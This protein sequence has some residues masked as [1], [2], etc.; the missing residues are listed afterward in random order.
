MLWSSSVRGSGEKARGGMRGGVGVCVYGG[1][2]EL[3]VCIRDD[4][5]VQLRA[6]ISL[7]L[8][9]AS[10]PVSPVLFFKSPQKKNKPNY[11]CCFFAHKR[12]KKGAELVSKMLIGGRWRGGGALEILILTHSLDFATR[13]QGV[14]DCSPEFL[15]LL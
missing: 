13:F 9:R 10:C 7:L 8:F 3:N 2:G 5:P 1:D 11:Y 12:K 6:C 4:E 15:V 14:V